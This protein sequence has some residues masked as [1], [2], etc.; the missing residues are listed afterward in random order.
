[1]YHH[2]FYQVTLAGQVLFYLLAG[3][4]AVLEFTGRM[5]IPARTR[6]SERTGTP[7]DRREVA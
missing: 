4:G 2:V 5:E 7:R 3:Y 6:A 1:V